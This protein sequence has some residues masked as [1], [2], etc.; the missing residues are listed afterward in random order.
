M[1]AC[2]CRWVVVGEG[3]G[4]PCVAARAS[5]DAPQ[6]PPPSSLQGVTILAQP[7]TADFVFESVRWRDARPDA[8]GQP[9]ATQALV[10]AMGE[11]AEGGW[12]EREV[13]WR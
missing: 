4:R 6:L 2:P 1:T 3:S 11:R 9:V 8:G 7:D 10:G 12:S 5:H 13:A